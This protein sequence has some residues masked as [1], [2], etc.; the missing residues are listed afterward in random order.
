[1]VVKMM[2]WPPWPPVSSRKFEVKIAIQK[3]QGLN[4]VQF[5]AENDDVS[6]K[7]TVVVELK[8]K[9]QKSIA[10]GP[11]RRSVRRNFTKEGSFFGDG[12]FEWNEEFKTVRNFSGNKEGLFHPREVA[13]YVFSSLNQEPRNGVLVGTAIL[14]LAEY[15]STANDKELEI[16]VPL[17]VPGRTSDGT[18]LLF[19]SLRLM[20]LGTDQEPLR[21][22]PRFNQTV[23]SPSSED[24]L[25]SQKDE[26]SG[27]K[28]G[29]IKVRIFRGTKKACHEEEGS[30]GKSSVRREVAEYNYAFDTYSLD[31]DAEAEVEESNGN[32]NSWL[33]F[34]Y[35][36]V[37]YANFNGGSLYSS[38]IIDSKDEGWIYYNNHKPDLAPFCF[39]HSTA[40]VYEQS[41]RQ[42]PKHRILPWRKR[43]LN[44]RTPKPKVKR[45][46]LLKK[47]YGEDGG[48]DIDFDRRQLSS[49]DESTFGWNKS[50]EGSTISGS[51]FSEFGDDHFAVGSWEQ[52][53]LIS[54]DGLMK[55]QAQVFFGSIDQRSERAAGESACTALVAV[56]ANWLQ[57]NQYEVPTKSEFDS[58]IR[59]GSLAW[60]NLCEKEDYRQQFPDRHFDL[61]TVLQAKVRPLS[62]VA[63]KSF[64]GFFHPEGLDF[65]FLHG[66]M[67][68]DCIWEEI[69]HNSSNWSNNGDPLVYIVSWNDHFFVLKVK[70][71]AYYIIDTLGERLY[72]GCNQAYVLKFDKDTSILRLPAETKALAEKTAME[73]WQPS[74][75]KGKNSAEVNLQLTPKKAGGQNE[76]G[77]SEKDEEIMCKGKESCKEYIKSFL[78]AIPI[79]ELQADIKKGLM[80]STPIHHRLQIEFHYTQLTESAVEYSSKDAA[81]PI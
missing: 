47:N 52:K 69:S 66:A 57:S 53:E 35:E 60:R 29:L 20:E 79:R 80:A 27:L 74:K 59:D 9:G 23:S 16:N 63:E 31:D 58:L 42:S 67:T 61:E 71:D 36:T 64:I 3:L 12:L 41:L 55:L 76:V 40:T 1:M 38:T 15:A 6:K 70:Q 5:D 50:E 11:L 77:N 39:G 13:F 34:N 14:N 26:F 73:N 45:E 43:K 18:P 75:S 2:R 44:F 51:S 8:S 24:D 25:S 4:M 72:E 28:A 7:R 17:M 54:R 62:V 32:S 46:P 49:S 65:N 78:A 81:P 21:A 68:F 10:L 33:S 19:I 30:E 22:I 48:D 56:I 37:A